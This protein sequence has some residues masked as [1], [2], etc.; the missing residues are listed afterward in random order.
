[1]PYTVVSDGAG[2]VC[3]YLKASVLT[4]AIG[5]MVVGVLVYFALQAPMS[6]KLTESKIVIRKL[7][8]T[9]EIAYGEI[10]K[11]GEYGFDQGDVRVMGS[12]GFFGYTGS[13]K[14]KVLGAYTAYVG[15]LRQA[16][17]IQTKEGKCFVVSCDKRGDVL[18][19]IK[20]EMNH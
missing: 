16:F 11:A 13:F 12:G 18:A 2:I 9:V 1:M 20:E 14:N 7:V 4:S 5:V 10:V 6:I 15:D 17:F 19:R 8:G 3:G